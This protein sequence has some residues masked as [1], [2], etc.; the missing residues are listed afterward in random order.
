VVASPRRVQ[1][2]LTCHVSKLGTYEEAAA[3]QPKIVPMSTIDRE[4]AGAAAPEA[5]EPPL[6]QPTGCA[7]R[8]PTFAAMAPLTGVQSSVQPDIFCSAMHGASPLGGMVSMYL[9]MSAFHL[10]P[11]L[12]LIFG[13]GNGARQS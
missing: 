10:T 7:F 3:G 6:A 11:W 13:R 5:I 9:L 8:A 2:E 1:Q 12:K 4:S